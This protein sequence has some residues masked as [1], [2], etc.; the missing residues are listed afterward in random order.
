MT[1]YADYFFYKAVDGSVLMDKELKPES[2]EV[3]EG[4]VFVAHITEERQ[5]IFKKQKQE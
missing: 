1:M 4:D 3:E 2:L 5:I